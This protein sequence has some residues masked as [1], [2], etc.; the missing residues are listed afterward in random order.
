MEQSL[1]YL[2]KVFD[3]SLTSFEILFLEKIANMPD[4]TTIIVNGGEFSGKSKLFN[5][6]KFFLEFLNKKCFM[7]VPTAMAIC[8]YEF[9]T[10]TFNHLVKSHPSTLTT[11]EYFIFNDASVLTHEYYQ[12]INTKIP[13]TSKIVMFINPKTFIPYGYNKKNVLN[14]IHPIVNLTSEHTSLNGIAENR[15]YKSILRLSNKSL[16]EPTTIIP[17]FTLFHNDI[18]TFTNYLRSKIYGK[19][20]TMNAFQVGD[21]VKINQSNYPNIK[22]R[23]G[24][25]SQTTATKLKIWV[26]GINEKIYISRTRNILQ[27]SWIGTI[28]STFGSKMTQFPLIYLYLP[29]STLLDTTLNNY[30]T[31]LTFYHKIIIFSNIEFTD[32]NTS[33]K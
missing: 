25:V 27:M 6:L 9:C 19:D 10:K 17:F 29:N 11:Y 4:S 1:N 12:M 7:T 30:I 3:T 2:K 28:H 22:G 18:T 20:V 32:S 8:D 21:Q 24:R 14:Y 33:L 26:P 13:S 23:V 31:H 5:F 15:I 16:L